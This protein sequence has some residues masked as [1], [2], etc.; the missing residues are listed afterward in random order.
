DAVR[1]TLDN[2]LPDQAGRLS[3]AGSSLHGFRLDSTGVARSGDSATI[4]VGALRHHHR[5]SVINEH[6][7][8]ANVFQSYSAGDLVGLGPRGWKRRS[9]PSLPAAVALAVHTWPLECNLRPRVLRRMDVD[10]PAH[11]RGR[12]RLLDP[13]DPATGDLQ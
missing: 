3:C 5:S 10:H 6:Y 4:C 8:M 1:S 7:V 2:W 9:M 13:P 12:V 11:R